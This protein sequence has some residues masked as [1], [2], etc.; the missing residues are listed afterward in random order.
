[1]LAIVTDS[2]S[3][4]TP[5]ELKTMDVHVVRLYVAFQGKTHKDWLEIN[6]KDIIAGVQAGADLPSTSQPSPEDFAAAY[7]SAKA[8]GATEILVVTISSEISGTFQSA[9]LAAKEA[10]VPV[11]IVDSRGASAGVGWLVRQAV[12]LRTAGTPV[13]D[14]EATLNRLKADQIVLFS[15]GTLEYLQKGGRVSRVSALLG[16]MLNI[17]PILTLDDGKIVPAAKARGTKKAIA[18]IV[19]RV[20]AHAAAHPGGL[21]LDFLHIQDEPAAQTLRQAMK[22]AGIEFQDGQVYEFGAVIAAHVGPGTFGVYAHAV[23]A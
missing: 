7:R 8:Q 22:D 14:I 13:A 16:G 4:L 23:P 20:R 15:V 1:M 21:V 6:P 19:D 5:A 18:E 12:K 11:T 3:D 17:R 9:N 2:T 10:G